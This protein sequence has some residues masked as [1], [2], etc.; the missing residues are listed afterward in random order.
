MKELE[1]RDVVL[2]QGEA[3]ERLVNRARLP[4]AAEGLAVAAELL[5]ALVLEADAEKDD[6]EV[7]ANYG[8]L[9]GV[10]GMITGLQ[11]GVTRVERLRELI[12]GG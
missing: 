2:Q 6:V 12:N 11:S 5:Q 4:G 10:V 3:W 7:L 8:R 1:A 9:A